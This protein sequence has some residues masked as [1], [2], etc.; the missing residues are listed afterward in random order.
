MKPKVAQKNR[1]VF[2]AKQGT[3]LISLN[4]TEKTGFETG[5]LT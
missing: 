5:A 1:F 4:S 3:V 2:F